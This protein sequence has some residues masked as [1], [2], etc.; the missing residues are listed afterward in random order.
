VLFQK[1]K[2]LSETK[3]AVLEIGYQPFRRTAP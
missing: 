1:L 3:G 2:A